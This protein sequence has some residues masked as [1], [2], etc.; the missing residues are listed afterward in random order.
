MSTPFELRPPNNQSSHDTAFTEIQTLIQM[1]SRRVV[2]TD[3]QIGRFATILNP[4]GQDADQNT[5]IAP[6]LPIGEL[7]MT[8]AMPGHAQTFAKMH[9]LI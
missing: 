6:A 7:G 1:I 2:C 4:V 9:A 5:G 3:M 8:H